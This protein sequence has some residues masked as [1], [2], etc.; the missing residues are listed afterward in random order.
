[1][2]CPLQSIC[3]EFDAH[4]CLAKSKDPLCFVVRHGSIRANVDP[5]Q[6]GVT[7]DDQIIG[8]NVP[9]TI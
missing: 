8:A 2:A 1:M 5:I 9:A 3:R 7:H 6:L 4:V